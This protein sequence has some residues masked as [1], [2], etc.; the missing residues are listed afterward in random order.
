MN[1]NLEEGEEA[2][3][4]FDVEKISELANAIKFNGGANFNHN[5]FWQSLT[6]IYKGG[7]G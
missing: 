6:P 7:G 5:F 1:K 2:I 4:E 3:R